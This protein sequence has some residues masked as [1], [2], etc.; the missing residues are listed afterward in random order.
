[1]GNGR[2]GRS[3]IERKMI[4]LPHTNNLYHINYNYENIIT[5]QA[6]PFCRTFALRILLVV[7]W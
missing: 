3:I 6:T 5:T 7:G 2:N 4:P 1:M